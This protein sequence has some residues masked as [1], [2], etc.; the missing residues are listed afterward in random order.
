MKKFLMF[1]IIILSGVFLT[2][3]INPAENISVESKITHVIIYPEWAYVTR[4]A[5]INADKGLNRIVFKKLPTWIDPESIQVKVTPSNS[6]KIIQAEAATIYLNQISEK[7]V[8]QLKD[9][10]TN[11]YDMIEDYNSQITALQS[12]KEYLLSLIKWSVSENKNDKE[13]A[14]I[15]IKDIQ[16]LNSFIKIALNENLRKENELKRKIRDMTPELEAYNKKWAEMQSKVTLEQKEITVELES[17]VN[18]QAEVL[19]SYL[20]SGAGWYPIYDSRSGAD[21]KNI[22]LE[23]CAIIQQSTGEDWTD[24]QFRLSTIR[25]YLIREIPELNPWYVNNANFIQN[26]NANFSRSKSEAYGESLKSIQKKQ[27]DYITK[28]EDLSEQQAFDNYEKGNINFLD[29]MQQIEERGT[30]VEFDIKGLFSVKTDGKPVKMMINKTLMEAGRQFSAI[31]SISKNTYVTGTIINNSALPLLPGVVS[32]Y[33]NGS[34]IGKSKINFV[35]EKEKFDMF[36]GLEERIRVTR[37]LD[38]K[39]S[40]TSIL[41]FKRLL[42]VGYII[43]LENFLN[44]QVTIDLSDQIPVSQNDSVKIRLTATEP[45]VD[46]NDKGILLWKVS[47]NPSEKKSLYFEFEVE[48]PKDYSLTNVKELERSIE[49]MMQ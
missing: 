29:V 2:V 35:S 7:E 5:N 38:I 30:T 21:S 6:F 17:S 23:Y 37:T 39:K 34:F 20:I 15:N 42:K 36:M 14:K 10:I 24:A 4:K 27:K 26:N 19:V 13:S 40:A 9:K 47:L 12:E 18:G 41:G 28:N 22:D 3:Q 48:Y 49:N 11:I 33:K 46:K 25:P 32:V 44:E 1:S 16:D 31:P 8:Q 43:N 45:K